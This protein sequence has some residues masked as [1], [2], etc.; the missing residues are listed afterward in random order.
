MAF[1]Q[2]RH[3]VLSTVTSTGKLIYHRTVHF[4][5]SLNV[6]TE[7]TPAPA[8]VSAAGC[9]PFNSCQSTSINGRRRWGRGR[10]RVVGERVNTA[11][12]AGKICRNI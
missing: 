6:Y 10:K 2:N 7:I 3:T 4:K 8:A 12:R 9:M 1:G 5:I 11:G